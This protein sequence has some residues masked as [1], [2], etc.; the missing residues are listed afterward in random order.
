ME[1]VRLLIDGQPVEVEPGATI[2]EAARRIGID[3]PTLC[4]HPALG[5]GGACRVCVCEVEGAKTLVA[6]CV[7]PASDGMV[8][9]THSK[10]VRD[11]RRMV[12]EL[13]LAAHPQDCLA[14]A[15]SD[16]CEL[17]RL[18]ARLNAEPARFRREEGGAGRRRV[19][20]VAG[21][22]PVQVHPVR[23]MRQG[24][25]GRPGRR[26]HRLRPQGHRSRGGAGLTAIPWRTPGA[27]S[28]ASALRCA[29]WAPSW[30]RT[31]RT[32]SLRR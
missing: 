24:L 22:G 7:C 20:P 30:S 31:T 16:T 18:A 12:V 1:R 9:W 27:S 5:G 6:A 11:A 23:A 17:R 26:R 2:L 29:R 19:Q 3:I 10:A 15:R 21:P 4:H 13:I 28:A 8:V 32:A 25:P 14:C